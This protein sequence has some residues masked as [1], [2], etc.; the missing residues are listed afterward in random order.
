M[1]RKSRIVV[2]DLP[3]HVIQ[4]GNRKQRVFFQDDDY[5]FYKYLLHKECTNT[6]TEIW[7]Y[8]LMPNHVH[9]ILVPRKEND[10]R[11]VLSETHRQYTRMIN[12][13]EGW[14]GYL[15]QGRFLSYPMQETYLRQAVRYV[16]LNPVRA[17]LVRSPEEYPWSSAAAHLFG[18]EDILVT[19]TALLEVDSQYI[20][21]LTEGV[22]EETAHSLL[23]HAESGYL[24]GDT[25]FV[26]Q[27][28]SETGL[29]LT[30][31]KRG[32]KPGT[33]FAQGYEK[34]RKPGT[35]DGSLEDREASEGDG[36]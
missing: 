36:R 12:K 27:L 31:G 1:A 14:S 10:L 28:E 8:C 15:W 22:D 9:L 19:M 24:L 21:L 29:T 3:H 30:P 17:G 26:Q 6:G 4:R 13:R 16:E 2:P 32:R 25:E 7:A 23:K 34:K 18:K 33:R 20:D 35:T 5:R 11:A